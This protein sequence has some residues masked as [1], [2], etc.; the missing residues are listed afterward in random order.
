MMDKI[1]GNEP[2]ESKAIDLIVESDGARVP[3]ILTAFNGED[4][5]V[6]NDAGWR[7]RYVMFTLVDGRVHESF[8]DPYKADHHMVEQDVFQFCHSVKRGWETYGREG[9]D[10]TH[11]EHGKGHR[12]EE[13]DI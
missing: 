10:W 13:F 3:M 11:L 2:M 12:V 9:I 7:G 8:T 6:L 5:E 4:N 1:Q